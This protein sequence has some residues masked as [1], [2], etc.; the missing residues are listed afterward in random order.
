[1]LLS[2]SK[3]RRIAEARE[4][5]EAARAR[6]AAEAVDLDGLTDECARSAIDKALL[7]QQR[8]SDAL[9]I[10]YDKVAKDGILALAKLEA[11]VRHSGLER[12]LLELVK[13]RAS[14]LNGCAYCVRVH[15]ERATAA[16]VSAAALL[17]GDDFTVGQRVP[18]GYDV[19][20]VPYDY[21]DRYYD[22]P[23]AHYRYSDGYVYRVDPTTQLVA[24]AIDL[25]V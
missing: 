3:A 6:D 25:L 14:Q 21:R 17:T 19:Y 24:A 15:V 20:N 13:T 16:G 10:E 1:M 22:T 8:S 9:H 12:S 23:E 18:A 7:A 11:Y 2:L 5:S 4:A